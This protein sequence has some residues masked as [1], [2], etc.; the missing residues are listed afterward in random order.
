M[1]PFAQSMVLSAST[2]YCIS[3]TSNI[4]LEFN[5]IL[6]QLS[7]SSQ[8]NVINHVLQIMGYMVDVPEAL[9]AFLVTGYWIMRNSNEPGKVS[10]MLLGRAGKSSDSKEAF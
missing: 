9:V 6:D 4:T 8:K 2:I 7:P 1:P 3:A 10:V 5:L